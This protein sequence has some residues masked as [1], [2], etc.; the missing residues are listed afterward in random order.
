MK[1]N[2]IPKKGLWDGIADFINENFNK[3]DTSVES[4]KDATVKTCGYFSTLEALQQAYPKA[5]AGSKAYVG[6]SYPY[7]IYL[8][9]D[10]ALAWVDSG[11]TGGEENV[12]LGDYYTKDETDE[13]Y[14]KTGTTVQK[15]VE[16]D[17]NQVSSDAVFQELV[18]K[19]DKMEE[20]VTDFSITTKL[21]VRYAN[22]QTQSSTKNSTVD[23]F[24]VEG[25]TTIRLLAN[26]T[27]SAVDTGIAFYDKE[28]VY[29]SG[30]QDINT[31]EI[32]VV[33]RTIDVPM[34]AVYARATIRMGYEEKWYC[35]K[36]S[37]TYIEGDMPFSGRGM[38][39]GF[40]TTE[41]GVLK[42]PSDATTFRISNFIELGDANMLN[43]QYLGDDDGF[44]FNYIV[45]Y[46]GN[47]QGLNYVRIAS[48]NKVVDVIE[49]ARYMRITYKITESAFAEKFSVKITARYIKIAPREILYEMPVMGGTTP[50][51]VRTFFSFIRPKNAAL[52]VISEEESSAVLFSNEP[53]VGASSVY[54]PPNYSGDGDPVRLIMYMPGSGSVGST[55]PS[56][57]NKPFVD[58]FNAQGYA[59]AFCPNPYGVNS[60]FTYKAS[61][62][63]E[64]W[65]TPTSYAVYAAFYKNL[66]ERFN[67][68]REV[69]MYG[70]SQG[71]VQL[72][73][74]P[75]VVGIPTLAI[76]PL[77]CVFSALRG[78]WGYNDKERIASMKDLSFDGMETDENGNIVGAANVMLFEQE[79]AP[80]YGN[81]SGCTADRKVYLLTQANKIIGLTAGSI[82][83]TTLT[84]EDFINQY[85]DATIEEWKA[86][87]PKMATNIPHL[88]YVAKDDWTY[89]ETMKFHSM[90]NNAN[91]YC[92]VRLMPSGTSNPHNAA[93]SLAPTM[94]VETKFGGVMTVPIT[95]CEMDEFFKR[96]DI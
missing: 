44:R 11:A 66:I 78:F 76:C 95:C 60:D 89:T 5:G 73:S 46:D 29:I 32:G 68:K 61:D 10:S 79:G 55:T 40:D 88:C 12:E 90:I 21:L 72:S 58:Y 80:N 67:I 39:G 94:E 47:L 43:L 84:I 26:T 24:S 70:K 41:L 2:Q 13:R 31:G 14:I 25:F 15:V 8:W 77:S 45:W 64:F 48:Q 33:E 28:K 93:T 52:N 30:V 91:G 83:N 22:G 20:K 56:S 62:G 50:N 53:R 27:T 65:G 37:G 74:I 35:Y 49:G 86:L 71:G 19:A 63:F 59:V 57:G 82:N 17:T 54:V 38:I 75:Y 1:L 36:V 69:F 4:L 9:D 51:R 18:K 85:S 23:Y 96:Y 7:A 16:G 92:R 81:S 6:A 34:G 3:I 42:A 87:N